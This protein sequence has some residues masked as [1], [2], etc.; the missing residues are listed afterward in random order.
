[1]FAQE[2]KFMDG[3]YVLMHGVTRPRIFSAQCRCTITCAVSIHGN[4]S[5]YLD[6]AIQTFFQCHRFFTTWPSNACK[7]TYVLYF[8][9][10]I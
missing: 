10:F 3:L 2:L 8:P 1:M 5:A 9:G 4:A 6:N 7:W